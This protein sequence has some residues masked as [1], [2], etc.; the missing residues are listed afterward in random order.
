MTRRKLSR[1][2]RPK[3]KPEKE[4]MAKVMELIPQA[5]DPSGK[6]Y[7]TPRV[8]VNGGG[9][10]ASASASGRGLGLGRGV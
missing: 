6:L 7:S 4:K 3:R 10:S 8:C 9:A 2:R 1:L 5:F